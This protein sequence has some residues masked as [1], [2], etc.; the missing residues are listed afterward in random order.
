MY[1]AQRACYRT[2]GW[3]L[4]YYHHGNINMSCLH[5]DKITLSREAF[6]LQAG[7]VRIIKRDLTT[8]DFSIVKNIFTI[9]V[10]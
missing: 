3:V 4:H 5:V 2:H 1:D 8:T 7:L 6:N 9:T 10:G